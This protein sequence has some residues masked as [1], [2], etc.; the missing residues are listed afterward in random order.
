MCAKSRPSCSIT[1]CCSPPPAKPTR[2]LSASKSPN[3]RLTCCPKKKP[4]SPKRKGTCSPTISLPP[5]RRSLSLL[6]SKGPM[7]K[8][9]VSNKDESVRLFKNHVLELFTHVHWSVP[10]LLYAPA[11]VFFLLRPSIATGRSL[12]LVFVAGILI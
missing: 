10:I 7:V 9:Y 12:A 2:P 5:H 4:C 8:H 3:A 1:V 11:I 6:A